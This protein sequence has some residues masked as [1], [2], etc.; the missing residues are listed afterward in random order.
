MSTLRLV[1]PLGE[2]MFG[3]T[4]G[5]VDGRGSQNGLRRTLHRVEEIMTSISQS[6]VTEGLAKSLIHA[7]DYQWHSTV[8][9]YSECS[10]TKHTDKLVAVSSVARELDSTGILQSQRY[11]AG[12]WSVNIL[13]QM[14]W[15]T[16]VG[17]KT[18]RRKRVGE[19]GYVAPSWSWA[20]VEAPVQARPFWTEP[21]V[22][23]IPLAELRGAEVELATAYK[24]GSVTAG[25][26]RLRGHLNGVRSGTRDSKTHRLTDQ[27]TGGD[28]WF[29]SDTVEG[30][31]LIRQGNARKLVWMP[32]SVTFDQSISGNCLILLEVP[33]PHYGGPNRFINPGE[34]VYRRMGTGNFGRSIDMLQPTDVVLGLGTYPDVQI[35][36]ETRTGLELARGF[37]RKQTP[38]EEFVVI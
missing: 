22:T 33:G 27:A 7:F 36:G 19:E 34:K 14:A 3:K 2:V 11:L 15:I 1:T 29:C 5:L 37:Q 30:F 35:G 21:S 13:T 8:R 24:F 31:D 28:F 25:W 6:G 26:V 20:S 38:M 18:P 16:I 12:L 32:L 17:S 4:P 9:D 23:N 10:L